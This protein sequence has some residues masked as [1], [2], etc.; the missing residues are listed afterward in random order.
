MLPVEEMNELLGLGL[1]DRMGL[2]GR[3]V[4]LLE[5]SEFILVRDWFAKKLGERPR[6]FERP[7][8]SSI[9]HLYQ[10]YHVRTL[11]WWSCYIGLEDEHLPVA[12]DPHRSL[13]THSNLL[14]VPTFSAYSPDDWKDSCSSESWPFFFF[15]NQL[16]P[17]LSTI[18][19]LHFWA[20][21]SPFPKLVSIFI[22]KIVIFLVASETLKRNF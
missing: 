13:I 6:D 10:S 15:L 18:S 19:L 2:S 14:P 20:R 21:L 17:P 5:C 1:Q 9:W 3:S 12:S 22:L 16:S 4:P 8:P 11:Q 7:K